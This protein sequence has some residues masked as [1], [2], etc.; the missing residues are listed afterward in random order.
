MSPI[1]GV[2]LD[3][4]GT[5]VDSNDAHA[6]AW[7]EAFAKS[8]YHVSFDKVRACVGM[9]GDNLIQ[10]VIGLCKDNPHTKELTKNYTE[11]FRTVYRPY[12]RA[13]PDAKELVE[14]MHQ[15]GLAV[16]AASSS[17]KADVEA[18]LAVVGIS[19]IIDGYTSAADVDNSKP[20]PDLI[21]VALKKSE[22][23][24]NDTILIGD[25]PYDIQAAKRA[26]IFCIAFRSGGWKNHDLDGAI[27][28]YDGPSHLLAQYNKSVL[29]AGYVSHH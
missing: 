19:K 26:G 13:F 23:S 16:I 14:R 3:I 18:M 4:D 21:N 10:A 11:I 20:D 5:L 22:T 28:I 1:R 27:E 17:Q 8:G 29:T 9:G 7:V 15:N 25:T 6:R 24:T 12:V 2:L